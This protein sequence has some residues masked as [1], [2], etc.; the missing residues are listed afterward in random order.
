[1]WKGKWTPGGSG[2]HRDTS[3]TIKNDQK[4]PLGKKARGDVQKRGQKMQP[5]AYLPLRKKK[6][7]AK[8]MK[9]LIRGARKGATKGAKGR[10]K[11]AAAG[12]N[13]SRGI[14]AF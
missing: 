9:K 11:S 13:N 5:Y 7:Q 4:I 14:V 10:R 3:S 12:N 6:G 2:I 1:M 8:E